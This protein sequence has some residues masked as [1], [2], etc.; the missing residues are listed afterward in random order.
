MTIDVARQPKKRH[1]AQIPLVPPEPHLDPGADDPDAMALA[2][3]LPHDD[4]TPRPLAGF[5]FFWLRYVRAFRPQ[6]H[7]ANCLVGPYH[8]SIS[9]ELPIPARV[10]L[11]HHQPFAYLCGVSDTYAWASSLHLPLIYAPGEQVEVE[12]YNGV[13][14]TAHNA[15]EVAIPWVEDGWEAF[16]MSYTTCR[17]WQFGIHPFGYNGRTRPVEEELRSSEL[18]TKEVAELSWLRQRGKLTLEE[19]RARLHP[20]GEADGPSGADL[21]YTTESRREWEEPTEW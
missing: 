17:N 4:D 2:F 16:P 5:V 15:R 21:G 10:L 12:T 19:L 6:Y 11:D 9:A 14:I 1:L 8:R 3:Q 18:R 20:E 7:C 13:R